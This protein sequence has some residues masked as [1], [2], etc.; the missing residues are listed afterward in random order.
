MLSSNE[1]MDCEGRKPDHQFVKAPY[2]IGQGWASPEQR[3]TRE[4]YLGLHPIR[5]RHSDISLSVCNHGTK[6]NNLSYKL[7]I[8]HFNIL[9]TAAR[10]RGIRR[11]GVRLLNKMESEGLKPGSK[12]W[13]A[14]LVA[15]SKALET[16][17]AVQIFKRMVEQGKKPTMI[18]YGALLSALEKG[19]L[20]EEAIR[21]SEHM[22]KVGVKLNLYAY[23]IMASIYVGLGRF[24]LGK[25]IDF[26]PF[27]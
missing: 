10:K 14:I 9:L 15:C 4:A 18:S 21:V 23:T 5:E 2:R 20:Y 24:M 25:Y 19:K 17:A 8:S 26:F 1:T 3:R 13:N 16:Q 12:E 22:L 27:V 7:I 11:W 6:P